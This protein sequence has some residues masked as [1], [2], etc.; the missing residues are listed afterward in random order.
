MITLSPTLYVKLIT[1]VIEIYIYFST[2]K[3]KNNSLGQNIVQHKSPCDFPV[4]P[5]H[6][7]VLNGI[8]L[9]QEF[10]VWMSKLGLIF[11]GFMDSMHKICKKT[12]FMTLVLRA[13][14]IET[15]QAGVFNA[16]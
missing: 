11:M 4:F 14:S 9:K 16:P 5:D 8:H 2:Y 7:M 1:W 12:V 13:N 15:V 6:I 10:V 3:I